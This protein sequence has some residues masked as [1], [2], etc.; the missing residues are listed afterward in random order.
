MIM[1]MKTMTRVLKEQGAQNNTSC[2]KVAAM[3]KKRGKG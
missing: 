1:I 2:A 3:E